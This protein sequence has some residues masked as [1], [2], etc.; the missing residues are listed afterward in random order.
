VAYRVRRG[1]TLVGIAKRFNISMM[2]LWWANRLS[3]KSLSVGQRL[4]VPTVDGLTVKVRA[5][6]T[7]ASLAA[8]YAVDANRVREINGIGAADL[9][10]EDDRLL[11][12]GARGEPI[13]LAK[14]SWLWPVPGGHVSQPFRGDHHALD[15]AADPGTSVVAAR[16]GVVEFAGWR[17][18]CGGY[19][20]WIRQDDGLSTTYNHLSSVNVGGGQRVRPG[21]RIGGVGATGC[22]T[23]PHV[24]FEVWR[25]GIWNGGERL[26]P[27][28]FY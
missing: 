9:I 6:D 16:G 4:V 2:S 15:I 21:Q 7:V 18:N 10:T 12:P 26:D 23:G 8:K 24:H 14:D 22:V 27:S 3:S 20:V 25:G 13:K 5:G 19:Q 17:N 11:L 28:K 1:D